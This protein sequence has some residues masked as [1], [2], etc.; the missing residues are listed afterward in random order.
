MKQ[1]NHLSRRA[2][3]RGSAAAVGLIGLA[4]CAVP[5]AAPAGTE[6]GGEPGEAPVTLTF[7]VDII[8]D[9]HVEVR[10]KW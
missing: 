1:K 3:L 6:A 4:A 2:F 7:V 5:G 8:N 10:N 9:G